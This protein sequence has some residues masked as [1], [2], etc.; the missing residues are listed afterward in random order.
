[1]NRNVVGR[2]TIFAEVQ[3]CRFGAT[4][5]QFR[6]MEIITRDGLSYFVQNDE[7]ILEMESLA[8]AEALELVRQDAQ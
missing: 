3:V 1:L 4:G 2:M 8:E 5:E 6:G 7:G